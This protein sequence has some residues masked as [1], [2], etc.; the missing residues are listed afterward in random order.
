MIIFAQK[1]F[2]GGKAGLF[3]FIIRL[4]IYFRAF[5]SVA[6][7]VLQKILVPLLDMAIIFLGF[8]WI[9]PLWE[10]FRFG[11]IDYYP[12]EFMNYVVPVYLLF[13]AIGIAVS[14]AYKKP[15]SLSKLLR[16]IFWALIAI[17]LTYSL[18][19]EKYRF[20][21]ALILLGTAWAGL[22]LTVLRLLFHYLR[23]G[24]FR[25]DINRLKRIAIVG[26]SAEA[27]RI[28]QLL[29]ETRMKADVSG[30]IALDQSDKGQHYMGEIGQLKEI[31]KI[32]RIDELIFCA[33]NISST[34]IIRAMLDL[35]N[36]DVDYKIAPPKSVSIIGSNSIHTAGD[37]YVVNFNSIS[38][39]SNKRK[40]R[41]FDISAALSCL[42]LSPFILWYNKNKKQF[43]SN[44]FHVLSGKKT[45]VAYIHQPTTYEELPP[46]QP[47]ILNP[48][49]LFS[50]ANYD[51]QKATQLNMLYAKDYS[52]FTDAEILIKQWKNLDAS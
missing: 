15:F 20:S 35:S 27:N 21:R 1:H 52:I 30:F 2:P 18:V 17:L 13:F 8:Y 16:G 19:E 3:T 42:L 44:A 34:Q 6:K 49:H 48:G 50:D 4:A 39:A 32:N 40:K 37:L 5:L 33:E 24:G 29:N 38:K 11:S 23:V 41:L 22:A 25:L 26:H 43:L 14:G 47:G 28:K 7:R 31:V 51:E 46:I 36:G 45:W 9:T 12:S 10:N